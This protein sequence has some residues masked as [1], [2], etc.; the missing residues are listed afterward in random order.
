MALKI[1]HAGLQLEEAFHDSI[2]HLPTQAFILDLSDAVID[3]MIESVAQGHEI[4]LSLGN[5]PTFLYG[6]S[7][8]HI[9]A[10]TEDSNDD[11]ELFLANAASSSPKVERLPQ[12]AMSLFRKPELGDPWDQ[13]RTGSSEDEDD[14]Y[15]EEASP[16]PEDAN[17]QQSHA[18]LNTDI[19]LLRSSLAQKEAEKQE[20][21]T[22]VI[23]GSGPASNGKNIK[24]AVGSLHKALSGRRSPNGRTSVSPLPTSPA[25]SAIGSPSLAPNDASSQ[26]AKRA[27]APIIHELAFKEQ[28]YDI[29]WQ[30]YPGASEV[31]FRNALEKVADL[32]EDSQNYC[33]R[34]KYWREL[35]VWNHEY[36]S[37]DERQQAIDNAIRQYDKMRLSQS[38]PEWEKL[39][40]KEERGQGRILSKIHAAIAKGPPATKTK[41]QRTDESGDSGGG[42]GS[43]RD[44]SGEYG[45]GSHRTDEEG[46]D[47]ES[48]S[49]SPYQQGA[50]A[51]K[52]KVSAREKRLLSTKKKT[53]PAPTSVPS[54]TP[55]VSPT[56][57]TVAKPSAEKTKFKSNE[58]I[59]NSDSS[60]SE[61]ESMPLATAVRQSKLSAANTKP[62]VTAK[63]NTKVALSSS[64][65]DK[66]RKGPVVAP[67]ADVRKPKPS[68]IK[69]VVKSQITA[70]PLLKKRIRQDED[71]SSS[72][73]SSDGPLSKRV[74]PGKP[75]P[76]LLP[77]KDHEK[78]HQPR[79]QQAAPPPARASNVSPNSTTSSS[80]N[81]SGGRSGHVRNGSAP[82]NKPKNNNSPTKS[83][84][85]AASPPANASEIDLSSEESV[86]P[87]GSSN[88]N[89]KRKMVNE[90]RNNLDGTDSSTNNGKPKK[91][92]HLPEDVVEQARKFKIYYEKYEA[93]YKDISSRD[94][95][96]KAQVVYLLAM[97]HRLQLMKENIYSEAMVR[98]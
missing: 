7:S 75:A 3:G 10:T 78:Y 76:K 38:E 82:S 74:K 98:A 25:L 58:F 30:K 91:R 51:A 27:R 81:H 5:T 79:Q 89:Q 84:P 39:L 20:K 86:P 11:L 28:P 59:T 16:E 56:K 4:R 29:L 71:D 1:P 52:K 47:S 18:A 83:S 46:A 67:P 60:A 26:Q 12:F 19:A 6:N 92:K 2:D 63:A 95:P 94:N 32:Y 55:K 77:T 50:T 97:H 9:E 34:K 72:S 68:P 33:L 31:D 80:S 23:E 8:H 88:T 17:D 24:R 87:I 37:N 73:S 21:S 40:R 22:K 45:N 64:I 42:S 14:E 49:A 13:Y 90:R 66:A 44:D 65:G 85:L 48:I 53:N 41:G 43:G 36:A 96:P 54:S 57:P 70:K 62:S 15:E 61:S 35:D 69:E 93:L